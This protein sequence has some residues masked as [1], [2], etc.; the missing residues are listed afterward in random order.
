M[1]RRCLDYRTPSRV[2]RHPMSQATGAV[3]DKVHHECET[4]AAVIWVYIKLYK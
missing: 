2:E 1:F 4:L 3:K